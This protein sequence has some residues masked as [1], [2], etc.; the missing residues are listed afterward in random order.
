VNVPFFLFFSLPFFFFRKLT[1]RA[2]DFAVDL[3]K[4]KYFAKE[5]QGG[6]ATPP[7][8]LPMGIAHTVGLCCVEPAVTTGHS[9]G[10]LPPA[11][12]PPPPRGTVAT[13]EGVLGQDSTGIDWN[14]AGGWIG[15]E[16]WGPPGLHRIAHIHLSFQRTSRNRLGASAFRP[17]GP[18]TSLGARACD[19]PVAWLPT[20]IAHFGMHLPTP[21]C[22]ARAARRESS[23]SLSSIADTEV[24]LL[25]L[26]KCSLTIWC[27]LTLATLYSLP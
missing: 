22:L 10:N 15:P 19:E 16:N 26:N 5:T 6:V 3:P 7:P 2:W 9:L 17:I 18:S 1:V 24:T 8:W 21:L 14:P 11:A 13:T 27:R 12:P 25:I 4:A 23:A 20:A